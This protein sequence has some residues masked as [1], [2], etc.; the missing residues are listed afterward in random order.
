MSIDADMAKSEPL[1]R[2]CDLVQQAS[3]EDGV[4]TSLNYLPKPG[5]AN[6]GIGFE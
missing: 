4:G 3:T 5:V 6:A 1:Y 2:I